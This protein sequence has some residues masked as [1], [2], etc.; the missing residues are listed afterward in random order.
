M[1]TSANDDLFEVQ[2]RGARNTQPD[3]AGRPR[4]KPR[5]PRGELRFPPGDLGPA[6]PVGADLR[7]QRDGALVTAFAPVLDLDPLDLLR[8]AEVVFDPGIHLLLGMENE[9]GARTV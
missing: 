1:V 4:R 5:G 9:V 2:G 3:V 7:D 6:V 8:R